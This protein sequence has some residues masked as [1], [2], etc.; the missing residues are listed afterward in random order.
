MFDFVI[1][2]RIKMFSSCENKYIKH[3]YLPV[4]VFLV[5]PVDTLAVGAVFGLLAPVPAGFLSAGGVLV[6]AAPILLGAAV[7]LGFGLAF[8]PFAC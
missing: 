2:C 6:L 3:K 5:R 7:V 4:V 1:I 8:A